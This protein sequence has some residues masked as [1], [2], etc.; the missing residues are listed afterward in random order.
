MHLLFNA[1][2]S[3]FNKAP[4]LPTRI[5]WGAIDR[6]LDLLGWLRFGLLI[7]LPKTVLI[8][9][10]LGF[11]LLGL[12][13]GCLNSNSSS[14]HNQAACLD[15]H[16]NPP[17]T[18]EHTY[19]LFSQSKR[20]E[21]MTCIDC[22]ASSVKKMNW[23][24]GVVK[25]GTLLRGYG[26][27]QKTDSSW[28]FSWKDVLLARQS[29]CKFRYSGDTIYSYALDSFPGPVKILDDQDSVQIFPKKFRV[30]YNSS[31]DS[32]QEY[33]PCEY[34][35]FSRAIYKWEKTPMNIVVTV[36]GSKSHYYR[37]TVYDS[38]F[39][40]I[41]ST[42]TNDIEFN[43]SQSAPK[44]F[45]LL[46]EEQLEDVLTTL[47]N[48]KRLLLTN[49]E[50]K[51]Y[52]VVGD[53]LYQVYPD[54]QINYNTPD[55]LG[56]TSLHGNGHVD[57]KFLHESY[58]YYK[59]SVVRIDTNKINGEITGGRAKSIGAWNPVRKS[60]WTK[61][62]SGGNCHDGMDRAETFWYSDKLPDFEKLN[63][64]EELEKK[65]QHE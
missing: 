39:Y 61:G 36:L 13:G 23:K 17:K 15:C 46:S 20:A 52:Q 43:L 50:G 37:D 40:Y 55:F 31:L 29:G 3:L 35:Y 6:C 47:P 7:D 44:F 16:Q 10:A 8:P 30:L 27:W 54:S 1:F 18:G 56:F 2:N 57:L 4:S 33:D 5:L 24:Y 45:S 59:D 12:L 21:Q 49:Y 22:H 53:S 38:L 25:K 32:I 58:T 11:T 62:V 63:F 19:H 48:G 9:L 64:K 14:A 60:C 34:R 28:I 41:P 65:G 51:T 26:K 42:Y